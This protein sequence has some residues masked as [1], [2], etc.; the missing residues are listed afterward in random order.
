MNENKKRT[1]FE[2]GGF[3]TLQM[4]RHM[5]SSRENTEFLST[6]EAKQAKILQHELTAIFMHVWRVLIMA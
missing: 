1:L 6:K 3:E 4:L 5:K 2:N